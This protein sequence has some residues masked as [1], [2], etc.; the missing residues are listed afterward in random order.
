MTTLLIF[1][2]AYIRANDISNIQAVVEFAKQEKRYE[3]LVKFLTM[4]QGLQRDQ[5]IES[6]L[7]L[8]LA[9]TNRLDEI[10]ELIS[11][12]NFVQIS[13]VADKCYKEKLFQACK[14]LYQSIPNHTK[15]AITYVHLKDYGAAVECAKKANNVKV[16]SDLNK[17]CLEEREFQLAEICALNIVHLAEELEILVNS[18]EGYGFFDQLIRVLEIAIDKEHATP[19]PGGKVSTSNNTLLLTELAIVYSRHCESKLMSHLNAHLQSINI[20]KVVVAL[21][22][23]H[24]W[25]ELVHIYLH[26]EDY[27][28]AIQTMIDHPIETWEHEKLCKAVLKCSIPDTL[29]KVTNMLKI[30]HNYL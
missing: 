14:I 13:Q 2:E 19:N 25:K 6:E 27:D 18:Y 24:L 8:A 23:G 15:L 22:D 5:F 12:P 10:S 30:W 3:D 11:K 16:W 4:A 29:L 26:H 17:A 9:M 7:A 28:K 20:A 21:Q 1:S